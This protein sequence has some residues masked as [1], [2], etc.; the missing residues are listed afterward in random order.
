M[1]PGDMIRY[2]ERIS[3][4]PDP[5]NFPT[6]DMFCWGMTGIIVRLLNARFGTCKHESAIEYLD[7]NG[8]FHTAKTKDVE[9][10][11]ES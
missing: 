6:T 7:I 3:T 2:R 9:L 8:D 5:S 1:K 4:D 11:S 10:I